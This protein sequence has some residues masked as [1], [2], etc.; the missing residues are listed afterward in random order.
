MRQKECLVPG[1][2][3]NSFTHGGECKT[4]RALLKG[5]PRANNTAGM[6][7][8]CPKMFLVPVSLVFGWDPAKVLDA[9]C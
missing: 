4:L 8:G 7:V 3:L 6:G 1:R 5:V 9:Q 2:T